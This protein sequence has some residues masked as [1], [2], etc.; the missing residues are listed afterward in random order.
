MKKSEVMDR[1]NLRANELKRE[2]AK[3]KAAGGVTMAA[4]PLER[5]LARLSEC[6][7]WVEQ[8]LTEDGTKP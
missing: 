4:K 2:I 1:I 7:Y 8:G 3:T 5:A 6:V